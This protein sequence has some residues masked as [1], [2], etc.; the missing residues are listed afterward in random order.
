M[1]QKEYAIA[2]G[3][4]HAERLPALDEYLLSTLSRG[5][6]Q[7]LANRLNQRLGT[8]DMGDTGVSVPARIFGMGLAPAEAVVKYLKE[9]KGMNYHSIGQTLNRDERGIWGTY[10]RAC[11]KRKA[12]FGELGSGHM[13]P[14]S[15]IAQRENSV[16]EHVLVRL[17]DTE[18]ITFSEAAKTL[19]KSYSTVYTT[20]TRAK[21]K[22]ASANT[23]PPKEVRGGR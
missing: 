23:T 18:K 6:I 2:A 10:R 5:Q 12:P 9:E 19:G 8:E 14:L 17:I 16:L 4:G 3:D 7:F 22:R 15:L 11:K 20:Y 13:I 1:Q 21:A